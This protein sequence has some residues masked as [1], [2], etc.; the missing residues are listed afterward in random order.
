[1]YIHSKLHCAFNWRRCAIIAS[2]LCLF[3]C[4]L[5]ACIYISAHPSHCI[6]KNWPIFCCAMQTCCAIKIIIY[7]SYHKDAKSG[8]KCGC[9]VGQILWLCVSDLV[10]MHFQLIIQLTTTTITVITNKGRKKNYSRR[11]KSILIDTKLQLNDAS[12]A[13]TACICNF[14]NCIDLPSEPHRNVRNANVTI[15]LNDMKEASFP[16]Q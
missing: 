9:F 11:P 14:S 15:R 12:H 7:K 3:K 1:M 6:G 16:S 10:F 2:W 13:F 5:C 8:R 4:D